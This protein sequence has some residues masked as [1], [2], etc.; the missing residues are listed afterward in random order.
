M[1]GFH[2][3][4]RQ[5]CVRRGHPSRAVSGLPETLFAKLQKV[6]QEKG[7]SS[8]LQ[9]ALNL[10]CFFKYFFMSVS[11]AFASLVKVHILYFIFNLHF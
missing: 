8:K 3:K 4:G 1:L 10:Q 6:R 9:R 7:R 5:K 2:P 11:D